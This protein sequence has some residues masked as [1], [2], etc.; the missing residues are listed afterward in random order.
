MIHIGQIDKNLAVSKTVK[1]MDLTFCSVKE[2]PFVI[3]GLLDSKKGEHFRRLPEAVAQQVNPGVFRLHTNTSGGRV[4]FKTDSSRIAIRVHMPNKCLMPHMPFLGSSGFDLYE[5]KAGVYDFKGSYRPPIDRDDT[6]ESIVQLEERELRDLVIHFPLYDNV[7]ELYVG[8]EPGAVLHEGD[9]Y[10]SSLPIVYYGSSITQGGCASRPGNSYTN[11]I[12]R[13][14]NIDHV[15]LGFSGNA[16]GEPAMA[17]Y[18]AS[19]PMSLFLYDYDHNSDIN[20]LER[21]HESFFLTIREKQPDLPVVLASR[22]DSPRTQKILLESLQRKRIIMTTYENALRRGDQNVY[23]VD[24]MTVFDEMAKIGMMPDSCTVDGVHP[25]D[26]G[27]A[28]MA[29]VFG[30]MIRNI[31]SI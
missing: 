6:W 8:I 29:N 11:L 30:N 1:D 21:T 3:Y 2:S 23:F 13:A 4:R 5:Q 20:G 31:L 17:E 12:T 18:I 28:C 10:A 19:L 26:L 14:T 7:T 24:G 9:T 25:N 15:N 27:F 16:K 22:T